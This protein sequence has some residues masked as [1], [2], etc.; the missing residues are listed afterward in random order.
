[1]AEVNIETTGIP[2]VNGTYTVQWEATLAT[3]GLPDEL[4][5]FK[6]ATLAFDHVATVADL[7][8]PLVPDPTKAFYRKVSLQRTTKISLQPKQAK[9]Q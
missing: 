8:F 4:F 5:V 2:E 7:V 3:D 9:P 6:R 1:M